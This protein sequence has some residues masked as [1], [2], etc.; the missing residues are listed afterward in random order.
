MDDKVPVKESLFAFGKHCVAIA[1]WVEGSDV[2][3]HF[4]V[5]RRRKSFKRVSNGTN[6]QKLQFERKRVPRNKLMELVSGEQVISS[7]T[8]E[9]AS[10]DHQQH[11]EITE[12]RLPGASK[13]GRVLKEADQTVKIKKCKPHLRL[14]IYMKSSIYKCGAQQRAVY[15]SFLVA[16]DLLECVRDELLQST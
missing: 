11:H 1:N 14:D 12:W 15:K 5:S 9:K 7:F 2:R 3:C 10:K 8:P 6:V 16:F 13:G 4:Q